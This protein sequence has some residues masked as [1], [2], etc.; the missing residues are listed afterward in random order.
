MSKIFFSCISIFTD[1]II[2]WGVVLQLIRLIC[3]IENIGQA[4]GFCAMRIII[5]RE[6]KRKKKEHPTLLIELS[7][8]T[9][10]SVEQVIG[11]KSQLDIK[12]QTFST[13]E[14]VFLFF[15]SLY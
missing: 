1:I 3:R 6:G 14:F 15:C 8:A 4:L 2:T 9:I 10:T 11:G 12:Y 5:Q 13:L 7:T